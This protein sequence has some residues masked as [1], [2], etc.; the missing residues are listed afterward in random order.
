MHLPDHTKKRVRKSLGTH[1]LD[2]ARERRDELFATLEAEWNDIKSEDLNEELI[3]VPSRV[4][5]MVIKP[6]RTLFPLI[7]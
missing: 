3:V 2:Q 7:S 1:D 4:K 5:A 6:I